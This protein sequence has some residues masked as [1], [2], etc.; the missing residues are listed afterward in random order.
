[1]KYAEQ[2]RTTNGGWWQLLLFWR[3][4]INKQKATLISAY[5]PTIDKSL[6]IKGSVLWATRHTY[7][8]IGK[9][10]KLIILGDFN[11]RVRTDHNTW[12]GVMGQQ[13]T[14]K[15]NSNGLLQTCTAHEL[16]ITN[17]LFRLPTRNKTMEEWCMWRQ[18]E[19][20][21]VWGRV[22]DWPQ[23]TIGVQAQ[24][25]KCHQAEGQVRQWGPTT[26]AWRRAS[27]VVLWISYNWGRL[28]SVQRHDPWHSFS[29]HRAH[30]A[31]KP[32]LVWWK[33]WRKQGHARR[34]ES[35]SQNLPTRPIICSQKYSFHQHLQ[36][37]TNQIKQ[38]LWLAAKADEIQKYADTY[39]SKRFYD[40]LKAV[41]G[42]QSSRTSPLLNVNATTLI[43][44]KPAI[45]NRWAEHFGAVLNRPADINAEAIACLPQVE[46]NQAT[47]YWKSPR[48]RCHPCRSIQAWWWHHRRMWDEEVIP[49][50]AFIIRLYKKGNRQLCDNYRYIVE[51]I[52]CIFGVNRANCDTSTKVGIGH[53]YGH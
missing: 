3:R 39:D 5:A 14:G 13:G 51:Q 4:R 23:T 16:I 34:E 24:E 20:V 46:T 36:D 10:E 15:C 43:T 25:D 50:N 45:L 44:D 53:L 21:N 27:W 40:A 33:L 32:G 7:H 9:S 12:S 26:R 2:I 28:S 48:C 17:T 49:Q 19:K 37:S 31:E 11:A 47:L 42:P 8:S 52:T 41:Y 6:R 1:M 30:H 29:A 35:S 38:D 18:S 22:L